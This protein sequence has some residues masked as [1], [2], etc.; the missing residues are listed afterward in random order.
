[1]CISAHCLIEV[2]A[3]A[4]TD[5]GTTRYG[6]VKL[7]SVPVWRASYAGPFPNLRGVNIIHVDALKCSAL[8][9]RHFDT[10]WDWKFSDEL[11]Q[12][13]QQLSDW[14]IIVGATADE[15]T[16]RLH[17]ALPILREIGV[18]VTD[19]G[20]RGA[21]AFLT[22]KGFPA[23]SVLR[24]Y[25]RPESY[26]NQPQFNVTVM[27]EKNTNSPCCCRDVAR[28]LSR[29]RSPNSPPEICPPKIRRKKLQRAELA[30]EFC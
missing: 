2:L 29:R 13:I 14:S 7:N 30:A 23:D 8:E 12:Y 25:N 22:Q 16:R 5:D 11:S 17:T 9:S 24:K 4:G 10:F 18:D 27:G 20:W 26:T 28:P 1:M 21:F 6:Y 3:Y 19:V 15:P